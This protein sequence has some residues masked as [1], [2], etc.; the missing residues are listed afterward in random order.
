MTNARK[1][2]FK[3]PKQPLPRSMDAINQDWGR[4]VAQLG[5]AR[6][7]IYALRKDARRL[8]KNA[9]NLN[10]EAAARKELDANTDE[11]SVVPAEELAKELT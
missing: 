8:E 10:Y 5:Q 4:L 3:L 11:K 9:E 1:K 6:Y 2:Q 7:Q